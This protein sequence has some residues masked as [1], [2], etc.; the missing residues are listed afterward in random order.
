VVHGVKSK[1][2]L[3]GFQIAL[4]G[5]ITVG[6]L[7]VLVAASFRYPQASPMP[8]E[9]TRYLHTR[10]DRNVIQVMPE[11]ARYDSTLTY[12]L[13]PGRCVF[14][15]REFSNEY[16]IN[17]LGVRDDEQSLLAPHTVVVGDSMAMGWG[18]NQDEAFPALYEATSGQRTLNAAIAS[19]GTVR[20]LRLLER[21]D[22]SALRN[23]VVQYNENDLLENSQLVERPPFQTLT[24]EHYRRTVEEQAA[25][26]R[27]MPGKYAFNVLVQ[28]KNMISAGHGPSAKGADV[29]AN[30]Q[31]EWFVGVLER[32]TLDL[33]GIRITVV[34][35]R[36]DFLDEVLVLARRSSTAWVREIDVLDISPVASIDGAGYVLDDH[37]TAIGHRAIARLLGDHLTK[38]E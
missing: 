31:A 34:S 19:Y 38:P 30:R 3:V 25:L 20:E 24:D 35:V 26:L 11:C 5:L 36:R 12:T 22:R 13:R 14:T 9:L 4:I 37:F 1:L 29:S 21:I 10:F 8:I 23:L 2:A 27:Y 33:N 18:V 28:L 7:E 32:S 6:L 16:Q 15:N 17:T